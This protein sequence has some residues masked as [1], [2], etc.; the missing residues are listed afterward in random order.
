MV[1]M[2]LLYRTLIA[3]VLV[4]AVAV[5]VLFIIDSWFLATPI[6]FAAMIATGVVGGFSWT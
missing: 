5:A 4:V 2:L 1:D 3:T 6:A